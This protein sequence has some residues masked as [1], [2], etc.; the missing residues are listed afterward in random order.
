[1]KIKHIIALSLVF[2]LVLS[3]CSG[4]SAIDAEQEAFNTT[5]DNK[6]IISERSPEQNA[7]V[8]LISAD[9]ENFLD[10][11]ELGK[12]LAVAK[13]DVQLY[14]DVTFSWTCKKDNEGYTLIYT[15]K[16]D[17]SDAVSVDTDAPTV[18]VSDLFVAKTY[19]W[20]V[21]THTPGG[22]NYSTVYTF[23]TADT[24]R[25]ISIEGVTNTRDVGGYLTVDGLSRVKQGMLYRGA[26]LDAITSDG[27]TKALEVY[28][29]KTDLDLR[30]PKDS[31]F[32]GAAVIGA[33]NY[34]N[35]QSIDY[36]AAFWDDYLQVM[37]DAVAVFAEE[38]NY[39]IYVHCSAG[40]DRTG[41]LCFIIGALLG[42]PEEKLYADYEL[43]Y[44]SA[45][46]YDK[47]DLRGHE[48]F[49][50]FLEAF[51][52]LEGDT[53]QVKAETYCKSVIGITDEQIAS[54]RSIL[55]EE[56]G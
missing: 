8:S 26:R 6:Q 54:I 5:I 33:P 21:V 30:K 11:Y 14:E 38:E 39:P 13:K 35:V 34:I 47:H 46:S 29:I 3:G 37:H 15:T 49:L 20:Q 52:A 48:W 44:M 19:Y 43:T 55:L 1:M 40:R 27:E 31:L 12:G 56:I 17:F 50:E 2:A 51:E 16:Q 24:P 36:A 7:T 25:I 9:L 10:G 32:T 28:K 53:L 45:N 4:G 41:T 23:Q 22:N 42:V 18:T